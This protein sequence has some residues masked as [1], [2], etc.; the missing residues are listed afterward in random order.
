MY[1]KGEG[2]EEEEEK[3]RKVK[4]TEEESNF[5]ANGYRYVEEKSKCNVNLRNAV[6]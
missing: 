5:I 4:R 6:L 1:W 3:S 2:K